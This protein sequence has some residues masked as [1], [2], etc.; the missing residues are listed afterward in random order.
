MYFNDIT[1]RFREDFLSVRPG[2]WSTAQFGVELRRDPAECRAPADWFR[3]TFQHRSDC[4]VGPATD[5]FALL[6][7]GSWFGAFEC[8]QLMDGGAENVLD[9]VVAVERVK[10]GGTCGMHRGEGSIRGCW[11]RHVTGGLVRC[12]RQ[13]TERGRPVAGLCES[14]GTVDRGARARIIR[15]GHL[16]NRQCPAGTGRSERHHMPNV[17]EAQIDLCSLGHFSALGPGCV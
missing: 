6:R 1:A 4:V 9:L 3:K 13:A 11:C 5:P 14:F 15:A 17:V 12:P 10:E 8:Q 2:D 7:N 16:E